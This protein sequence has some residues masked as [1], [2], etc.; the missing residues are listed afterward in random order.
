MMIRALQRR[1]IFTAMISLL[2]LLVIIIAGI[3]I[4]GYINMENSA[5]DT[6]EMLAYNPAPA[7]LEAPPEQKEERLPAFGYQL[8]P[9]GPDFINYF[10]VLTDATGQI[11]LADTHLATSLSDEEIAAYTDQVLAAGKERGKIA[12][13]KYLIAAQ[14]NGG[15]KIV[16]LDNSIQA[17]TLLSILVISGVVA[18]GCMALMFIIVLLISRRAVRPIADNIEK[19]RRFVTDAGHE[20]KTPLAIIMANTDALELHLGSSKW[21]H[22]IREQ[23]IRLNGLMKN[24]L[25]LARLDEDQAALP[26]AEVNFSQLLQNCLDSFNE[27]IERRRLSLVP[28]ISPDVIITSNKDSLLQLLSILLDNA[29]KYANTGGAI[30]IRL[31]KADKKAICE[32]QNTC[33]ELPDVPPAT[34]FDRFYRSDAA[35][36]QK[37]GGYGIG[38]SVAQAI[39]E[40][41]HGKIEALYL[42]PNSICFRI[43]I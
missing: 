9:N 24:L 14:D 29:V 26:L 3:A 17:Q 35:R 6:L 28:K 12:S 31:A 19:Q 22:N 30:T 40:V 11:V 25:T 41:L 18:I 10:T 4:I 7:Q 20:I 42:E 36:T 8:S 39:T 38:L 27:M 15:A 21:S 23:S 13:Y 37:N 1:F 16:F 43:E 2:V 33:D 5:N 32:I 34:L